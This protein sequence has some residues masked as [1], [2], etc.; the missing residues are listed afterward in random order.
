MQSMPSLA[1]CVSRAALLRI[2][3][4]VLVVFASGCVT[5]AKIPR[6]QEV[7]LQ[8]VWIHQPGARIAVSNKAIAGDAG[9]G[10]AGGGLIG[11]GAAGLA[12][13]PWAPLCMPFTALAGMLAGGVAGAGFGM[14]ESWDKEHV[15]SLNTRLN[16]Y[17]AK[18]DPA[19]QLKQALTT[20]AQATWT[21]GEGPSSAMVRVEMHDFSFHAFRAGQGAL[22]ARAVVKSDIPN[23]GNHWPVQQKAL[24][25]HGPALN[26]AVWLKL[27]DEELDVQFDLLY[28][29]IAELTF[30]DFAAR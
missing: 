2:A 4:C 18:R 30:A 3:A 17:F 11:A 29:R 7:D 28:R 22:F 6:D 8:F 24:D 12:C 19:A 25:L 23:S 26:A 15:E 9:I 13:G 10:A 1:N 21:L 14:L 16:D 27:S 20:R 5:V